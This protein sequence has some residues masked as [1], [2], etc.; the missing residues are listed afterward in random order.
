MFSP[1]QEQGFYLQLEFL[2]CLLMVKNLGEKQE[3]YQKP[4][5]EVSQC[6]QLSWDKLRLHQLSA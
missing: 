2:Q 5:V 6:M 4:I 1:T 3:S